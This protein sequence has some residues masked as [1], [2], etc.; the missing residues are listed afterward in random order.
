MIDLK[1]FEKIKAL[2]CDLYTDFSRFDW[3]NTDE[4]KVYKARYF[5][6]YRKTLVILSNRPRSGSLGVILLNRSRPPKQQVNELRHE[7]GHKRQVKQMSL[8][9]YLLIIG[10]PSLKEYSDKPYY[11]REWELTADIL[12]GVPL[13]S[14][15]QKPTR[16]D[17]ASAKE[18]LRLACSRRMGIV[19]KYRQ[20]KRYQRRQI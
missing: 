8:L 6:A 9:S 13:D 15:S 20:A 3:H 16:E 12:G 5:S 10:L 2:F 19:K 17:I 18:Y 7:Y 14:R 4:R 11:C 1:L